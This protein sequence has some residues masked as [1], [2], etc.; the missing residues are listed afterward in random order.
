ML[1]CSESTLIQRSFL[2]PGVL[3]LKGMLAVRVTYPARQLLKSDCHNVDKKQDSSV[4]QLQP[5]TGRV[6]CFKFSIAAKSNEWCA[7]SQRVIV[8]LA[9]CCP[10]VS[11]HACVRNLGLKAEDNLLGPVAVI[12]R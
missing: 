5:A 9:A 8:I 6:L 2:A 11:V 10:N 3:N 7:M 12:C 1:T 4:N